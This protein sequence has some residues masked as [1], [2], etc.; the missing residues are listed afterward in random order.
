MKIKGLQSTAC[1]SPK[2]QQW[3]QCDKHRK[4]MAGELGKSWPREG[5]EPVSSTVQGSQPIWRGSWGAYGCCECRNK[6]KRRWSFVS[7]QKKE[8]MKL[9]VSASPICTWHGFFEASTATSSCRETTVL[10]QNHLF[11]KGYGF[12]P[13]LW[14]ADCCPCVCILGQ[15]QGWEVALPPSIELCDLLT[16]ASQHLQA[17]RLHL[18]L[19]P[20]GRMWCH[21]AFC[22]FCQYLP[23]A[24]SWNC[25]AQTGRVR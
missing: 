5:E 23:A 14:E 20:P 13:R 1:W 4:L 10:L 7:Q 8:K 9:V 12:S 22:D 16:A 19:F 21:Q 6:R 25:L 24:L 3:N 11:W 15:N 17:V 18:G 2:E